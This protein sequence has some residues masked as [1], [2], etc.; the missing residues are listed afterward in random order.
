M[1]YIHENAAKLTFLWIHIQV[2]EPHEMPGHLPCS[3]GSGSQLVQQR[4]PVLY[5]KLFI[6]T[7]P[8]GIPDDTRPIE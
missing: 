3:L 2:G 1:A 6:G 7:D 5:K 4:L 8:S